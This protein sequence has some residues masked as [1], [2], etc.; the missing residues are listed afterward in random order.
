MLER[1]IA[2]IMVFKV[3]VDWIVHL[4]AASTDFSIISTNGGV[5]VDGGRC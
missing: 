1:L 4:T 5:T 2:I 3:V